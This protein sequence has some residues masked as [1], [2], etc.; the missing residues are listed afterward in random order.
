[1]PAVTGKVGMTI[2]PIK[3]IAI[4]LLYIFFIRMNF[5]VSKSY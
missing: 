3:N 1:L 4:K 5:I 2:K